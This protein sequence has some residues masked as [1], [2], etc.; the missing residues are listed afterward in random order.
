MPP[1]LSSSSH[2]QGTG[3]GG[4]TREEYYASSS[5]PK[6]PGSTAQT[7]FGFLLLPEEKDHRETRRPSLRTTAR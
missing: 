3:G 5:L 1:L 2:S 7:G 4:E 6:N